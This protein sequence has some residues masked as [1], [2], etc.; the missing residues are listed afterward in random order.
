MQHDMARGDDVCLQAWGSALPA[1]V[2]ACPHMDVVNRG[3][4]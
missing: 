1:G 2:E 4:Q 3:I